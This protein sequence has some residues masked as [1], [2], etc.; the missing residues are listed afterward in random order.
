MGS[1]ATEC[2]RTVGPIPGAASA[3]ATA[4]ASDGWAP[5]CVED[6]SLRGRSVLNMV[7][8]NRRAIGDLWARLRSRLSRASSGCRTM[9]NSHSTAPA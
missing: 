1:V 9:R 6:T 5:P 8:L 4:S 7:G 2:H 3:A